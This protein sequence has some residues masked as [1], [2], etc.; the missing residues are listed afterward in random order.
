MLKSLDATITLPNGAHVEC[1]KETL[2]YIMIGLGWGPDFKAS[3]ARSV[4]SVSDCAPLIEAEPA[5]PAKRGKSE[6]TV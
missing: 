6:K 5:K 2:K 1:T 3:L 4:S